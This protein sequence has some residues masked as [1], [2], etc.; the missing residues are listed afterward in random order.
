MAGI[1]KFLVL[2]N[3]SHNRD[4][5]WTPLRQIDKYPLFPGTATVGFD[6]ESRSMIMILGENPHLN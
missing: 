4:T 5:H 3:T 6:L 1:L 2:A